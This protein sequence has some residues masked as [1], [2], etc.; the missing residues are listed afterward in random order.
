[1]GFIKILFKLPQYNS[2]VSKFITVNDQK[3]EIKIYGS[4]PCPSPT[5]P[6]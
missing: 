6:L 1:M 2:V 4:T 3:A 5:L